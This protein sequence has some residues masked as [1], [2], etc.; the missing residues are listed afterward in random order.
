MK[1][2]TALLPAL[3]LLLLTTGCKKALGYLD[4]YVT[5]TAPLAVPATAQPAG[6]VVTLPDAPVATTAGTTYAAN[7][8]TADYVQ[9]VATDRLVLTIAGP[10]GQTFDFARRVGVY[11]T[12]AAAGSPRVLLARLDAVPAGQTTL[13]LA[14]TDNKYDVYLR[15]TPYLLSTTVE[16]VGAVA[17]PVALQATVRYKVRARRPD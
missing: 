7:G 9:D 3:A 4:F 2:K 13:A 11:I 6:T 12:G 5:D 17:Q 15:G 8:T 1:T 14:P 16:L 10:P